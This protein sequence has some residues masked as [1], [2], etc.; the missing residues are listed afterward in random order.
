MKVRFKKIQNNHAK[1][2]DDVIDG[3]TTELPEVGKVFC[4]TGPPRD[5]PVGMRRVNTSPVVSMTLKDKVYT[6]E[7]QS[8]STYEI[9]LL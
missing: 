4:M 3:E 2:R 8:G 9:E 5:I 7:T 6:V 1:I